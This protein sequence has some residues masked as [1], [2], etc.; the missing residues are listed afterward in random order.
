MKEKI[1]ETEKMK[2]GNQK[3]KRQEEEDERWKV[4]SYYNA[5]IHIFL[6]RI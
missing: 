2:E 4:I 3:K 5:Q 1:E 6:V